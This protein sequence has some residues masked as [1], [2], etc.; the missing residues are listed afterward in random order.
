MGLVA[1]QMGGKVGNKTLQGMDGDWLIEGAPITFLFTGMKANPAADPGKGIFLPDQVPG[2]FKIALNHF[3]NERNDVIPCGTGCI[4][5]RGFI[6][7]KRSLGPPGPCLVPGHIS[8]RNS[9]RGHFRFTIEE[10]LIS[11]F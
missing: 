9:D 2:S 11:H 5:G 3:E 1:G 6:L 10:Y 4:A 8:L 7:I